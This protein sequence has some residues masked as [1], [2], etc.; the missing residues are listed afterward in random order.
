MN[1]IKAAMPI[2]RATSQSKGCSP[3]STAI[4]LGNKAAAVKPCM[5][6]CWLTCVFIDTG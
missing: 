3:Q 4:A 1:N 6:A 2:T 5:A